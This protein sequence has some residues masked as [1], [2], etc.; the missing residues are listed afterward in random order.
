MHF[1]V[2][3]A[4][5]S[6]VEAGTRNSTVVHVLFAFSH[7]ERFFVLNFEDITGDPVVKLK[8]TIRQTSKHKHFRDKRPCLGGYISDPIIF[9]LMCYFIED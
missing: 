2:G 1:A 5:A 4:I 9:Q 3:T 7:S 6:I 8:S